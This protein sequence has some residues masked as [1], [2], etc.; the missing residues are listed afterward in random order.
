MLGE[1]G[2]GMRGQL[3]EEGR[4]LGHGQIG[5]ASGR[6]GWRERTRGAA[7]GQPPFD[8]AGTDLEDADDL[9]AG[10]ALIDRIQHP[11]A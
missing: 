8:G 7:L 6:R 2:V 9:V 1:R 3:A 10:H 5:L 11:L 4:T